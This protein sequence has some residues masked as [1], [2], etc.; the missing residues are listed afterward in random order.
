MAG[1]ECEFRQ[2]PPKVLQSKCP[3]CLLVLREPYQATCCGKSFCKKCIDRV[4]D[5]NGSCPTCKT[6][7]FFCYPNKGL[8]QSL[9]DF[10][11]YCSHKSKGCEWR[12]EL[13][14]LDK[15]LNSEPAADKSL[16]GC[17]FTVINCPLGHTGCDVKLPR[18]DIKAHLSDSHDTSDTVLE[19]ARLKGVMTELE[20]IKAKLDEAEREKV[21]LK[22]R[23]AELEDE[24]TKSSSECTPTLSYSD[25]WP[26]GPGELF[27]TNFEQ[28]K[29]SDEEWYSPPFYSHPYGYKMCLRVHCNGKSS[30]KGSHVSVFVHLMRGEFDE[31]LKWPFRGSIT[32]QLL[33]QERRRHGGH[34]SKTVYFNDRSPTGAGSRVSDGHVG[35]ASGSGLGFSQFVGHS[36]LRPQLLKNDCLRL[37]ISKIKLK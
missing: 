16:G 27:L 21:L 33:N 32:V 18:K 20:N 24:K 13:R 36:D 5:R 9:Y 4:K 30:G 34:C 2:E 17:P 37:C 28:R 15:H 22:Q 31:Q 12:G 29:R 3:I 10:E 8:E 19:A 14:E 11:V 7:N 23:V 35:M 25:Q 6:E 1:F 26:V